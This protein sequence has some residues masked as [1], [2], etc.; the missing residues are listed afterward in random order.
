MT[1]GPFIY[2]PNDVHIEYT[3]LHKWGKIV[4]IFRSHLYPDT[5]DQIGQFSKIAARVLKDFRPDVDMLALIGDPALG[6]LAVMTLCH[7]YG[8]K[9]ITVLKWDKHHGAYYPA[10][11]E[12]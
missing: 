7:S 1:H 6:S 4:T 8:H 10:T 2:V 12:S 9:R 5:V 3:N 11:L